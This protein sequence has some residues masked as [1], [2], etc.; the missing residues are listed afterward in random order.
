M[1]KFTWDGKPDKINRNLII[2]DY[3][4]GG[5]KMVDIYSYINSLKTKWIK[6]IIDNKNTGNW[7]ELYNKELEKLGGELIFKSNIK[8]NDTDQLKIKSLFLKEIVQAWAKIN[9]KDVNPE[10]ENI[11][12]QILWNNSNIKRN[13]RLFFY[14]SWY[15]RGITSIEHVYDYR[16]KII[17]IFSK[18]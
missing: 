3:S 4:E 14:N 18:F 1:H 15:N 16:K 17:F 5:L 7:K 13:G 2:Q 9:Y 8:E 12:K 10:E 6:R 11:S